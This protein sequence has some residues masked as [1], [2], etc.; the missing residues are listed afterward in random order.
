MIHANA[1]TTTSSMQFAC[2]AVLRVTR[3]AWCAEQSMGGINAGSTNPSYQ[4]IL[5]KSEISKSSV[6][7]LMGNFENSFSEKEN[8]SGRLALV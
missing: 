2:D 7:S 5:V 6:P 4:P 8:S 1:K 3:T